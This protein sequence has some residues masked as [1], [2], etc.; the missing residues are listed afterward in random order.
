MLEVSFWHFVMRFWLCFKSTGCL[1]CPKQNNYYDYDWRNTFN[2]LPRSIQVFAHIYDKL[3]ENPHKSASVRCWATISLQDSFSAP[4]TILLKPFSESLCPVWKHLHVSPLIYSFT[5]IYHHLYL[6]ITIVHK[7]ISP[8]S[9]F[10][11]CSGA[12]DHL[13]QSPPADGFCLVVMEL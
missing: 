7:N 11:C 3:N 8:Q 1:S 12:F 10:S 13:T 9:P 6:Y 4:Q 5:Q 2:I